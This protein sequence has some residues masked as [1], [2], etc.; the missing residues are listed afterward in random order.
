MAEVL[1]TVRPV[2]SA[3][4]LS[5]TQ[6]PSFDGALASVTT[7]LA[8]ASGGFLIGV[9]SCVPG[10]SDAQGIGAA[11]TYLR[12]YS[13]AAICGV[14]QEDDDGN[15]AAHN[16]KPGKPEDANKATPAGGVFERMDS[17]A[18]A[19]ILDR[20]REVTARCDAQDSTGAWAY[21]QEQNFD[22][23]E[24]V[25]LWSKLPSNVRTALKKAEAAT[26]ETK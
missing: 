20:A 2:F 8:H 23:D 3:N 15:A 7:I 19:F 17:E 21:I 14:A 4:G 18:Q 6:Q 25:A 22:A 26:K 10:K 24:K 9:A 5:V 1:N 16:K 12:R 11:T 13:L